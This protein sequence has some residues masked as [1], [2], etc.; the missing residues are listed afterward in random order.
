MVGIPAHCPHCGRVFVSSAFSFG[1]AATVVL[2]NNK[3]NCPFCGKTADIVD[4]T[5]NFLGNVVQVTN[6]PPR[7]IAIIKVLQAALNAAQQGEP[8]TKVLDKIKDASPELADQIQK[9]T[10]AS[11]KPLVGLLLLLLAGNCSIATNTSPDWNQLVDQVRVYATGG[12]PYPGLGNSAEKTKMNRHQR[13]SQERQT[14]K[15]LQQPE[16]PLPRKPAR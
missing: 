16:P 11:G 6:A 9:A 1:L 12:D 13:R 2:E 3:T 5:F 10:V 14:K 4:G 8:D 15:K 7:T